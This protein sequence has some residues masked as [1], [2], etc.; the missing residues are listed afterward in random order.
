M[1]PDDRM[2]DHIAPLWDHAGTHGTQL[3]RAYR[4]LEIAP[5]EAVQTFTSLAEQGSAT[6]M[7][8]LGCALRLGIGVAPDARRAEMWYRH[9]ADSGLSRAHYNLGRLYLDQQ[10]YF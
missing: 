3:M 6:A 5:E 2:K 9:A 8:Y 1:L 4:A 7:L 10:K